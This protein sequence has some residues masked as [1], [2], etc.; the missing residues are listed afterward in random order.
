M[1]ETL[2]RPDL[3]AK[4]PGLYPAM[5]IGIQPGIQKALWACPGHAQ[6]EEFMGSSKTSN[7]NISI[8]EDRFVPKLKKRLKFSVIKHGFQFTTSN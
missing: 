3:A 8:L 5:D 1:L 4:D 7:Q 2:K 6:H